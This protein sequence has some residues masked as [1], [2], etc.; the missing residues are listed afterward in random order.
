M[1]LGECSSHSPVCPTARKARQDG[2]WDMSQLSP[3]RQV[4]AGPH[5]HLDISLHMSAGQAT[6]R[7]TACCGIPCRLCTVPKPRLNRAT[8][9]N[10]IT[11]WLITRDCDSFPQSQGTQAWDAVGKGQTEVQTAWESK[12]GLEP[13]VGGLFFLAKRKVFSTWA[14]LMWKQAYNY[15]AKQRQTHVLLWCAPSEPA[16]REL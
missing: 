11:S 1:A 4:I 10:G 5:Q 2:S 14:N 9:T 12:G 8:S 15:M 7:L 13:A 3:S 16:G 6:C